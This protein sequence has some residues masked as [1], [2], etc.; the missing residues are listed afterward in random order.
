MLPP[1]HGLRKINECYRDVTSIGFRHSVG[2]D[3]LRASIFKASMPLQ[4]AGLIQRLEP[5]SEGAM[6]KRK[7]GEN[8]LAAWD[9]PQLTVQQYPVKTALR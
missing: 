1:E 4:T 7:L 3:S 8:G 5:R 9:C 2:L 6:L